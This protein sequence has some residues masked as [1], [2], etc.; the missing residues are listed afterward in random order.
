MCESIDKYNRIVIQYNET[1]PNNAVEI[2]EISESV[3]LSFLDRFSY[4]WQY[5]DERDSVSNTVT[6]EFLEKV[7]EISDKLGVNT[8]D[9]MAVMAFESWIDPH[10]V[11]SWGATGLIQFT[12]IGVSD[13]NVTVDELYQMTAVDQLDYVYSYLCN[14]GELNTLGDLY[15]AILWPEGVGKDEEKYVV[16]NVNNVKEKD[17][18]D[19]NKGLDTDCDGLITKKEATQTVIA[20]RNT[21]NKKEDNY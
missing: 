21:F 4:D 14:K 19:R 1:H 17:Y 7:V 16:W 5:H 10:M 6:L 15:M 9:L 20:R 2:A 12:N 13:L 11:N 3:N 18:Y 8:D